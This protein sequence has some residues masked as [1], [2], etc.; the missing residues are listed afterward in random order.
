[1]RSWYDVVL[2]ILVASKDIV[3]T[4]WW[5]A[6]EKILKG[7]LGRSPVPPIEKMRPAMPGIS[8]LTVPFDLK[9]RL[10][11]REGTDGLGMC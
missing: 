4:L 7:R 6:K 2:L 8:C 11:R 10:Q 3:V 1:M 9:C 5:K